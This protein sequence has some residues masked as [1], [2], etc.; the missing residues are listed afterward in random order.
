MYKNILVAIALDHSPDT[1]RA[2]EVARLLA[3]ADA[4]IT[5]L[6]VIEKIPSYA[7][8]EIPD[9][10]MEPTLGLYNAVEPV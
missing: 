8:I 10:V 2:I 5:A 9:V 1:N 3:E 7:A 4:T 6:H